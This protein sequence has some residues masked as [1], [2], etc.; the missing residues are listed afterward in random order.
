MKLLSVFIRT[1]KI[2]FTLGSILCTNVQS[3][4]MKIYSSP[5]GSKHLILSGEIGDG[6]F[7]N[8]IKALSNNSIGLVELNSNGGT[9]LEAMKMGRFIRQI[10]IDTVVQHKCLSACNFIFLGGNKRYVFRHAVVGQ[11]QGSYGS[12]VKLSPLDLISYNK[13]VA[14]FYREM[15]VPDDKN[16][17]SF[18]CENKWF[19]LGKKREFSYIS[20]KV[21]HE[22]PLNSS[23]MPKELVEYLITDLDAQ[24]YCVEPID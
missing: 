7:N 18:N 9:A 2:V 23:A 6:D 19:E 10:G 1:I 15:L 16:M 4:D 3:A 21:Y 22:I 14:Q 13:A 11:H 12:G 8:L 5:I 17:W 24:M 20:S